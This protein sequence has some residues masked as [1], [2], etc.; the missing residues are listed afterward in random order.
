MSQQNVIVFFNTRFRSVSRPDREKLLCAMIRVNYGT[1]WTGDAER[2]KDFFPSWYHANLSFGG[3]TNLIEMLS[4]FSD[5]PTQAGI[6]M[7]DASFQASEPTLIRENLT[8]SL[9]EVTSDVPYFPVE[10][11][12][13]I[14]TTA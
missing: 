4:P 5:E 3:L 14:K 7:E 8:D 10:T 6:R 12:G 9:G 13:T 11:T 2:L 1:P